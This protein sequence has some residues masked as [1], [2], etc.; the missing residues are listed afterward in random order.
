MR[1]ARLIAFSLVLS[2][3][4]RAA[5]NL[6]FDHP[7]WVLLLDAR[8]RGLLADPVGGQQALGEDE[9]QRALALLRL[10]PDP[11]LLP[12]DAE[13]FWIRPV[14]TATLRAALLHEHDRP[15][16]TA[17]RPRNL[18]GDLGVSCELQEGRPC[19]GGV[20]LMPELD[21]SAG[22]GSWLSASTRLRLDAGNNGYAPAVALDRAYLKAQLGFLAIEAGRDV[23]ALG[24][25]ARAALLVSRNAA[26]LDML[27]AWT[28]PLELPFFD[29][30]VS[31]LYFI[32]RLRDPQ[33]Y[34]GTFVDCTRMQLD[35]FNHL[36][37]GGSR[38]L[39]FGGSGAPTIG[40]GSF[41]G[42]HFSR[43]Y[44]STG[45]PLGDNRLAFD[46]AV[47]VP[48]LAGARFYTEVSFEDFRKQELNVF[49]YDADYLLGV[50]FRA[51]AAG[52][53][54]RVLFEAAKTGRLSQEGLYWLTGWTNAGRT[55]GSPLGPDGL[56]LYLHG[57]LELPFGRVSPWAEALRFSSDTFKD[58]GLGDG[59]VTVDRVGPAEKRL[60][61]GV[62]LSI[63]LRKVFLLEAN[64]YV[65]RVTTADFVDGAVRR[66]A[67]ALASFRY[68]SAF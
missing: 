28:R 65:E 30:R 38:L 10:A 25:S 58:D 8:A 46:A 44:D 52:P 62:E 56:S 49:R 63:P 31:F 53:L 35:L 32:A 4:A 59:G 23:V 7:D 45:A 39:Q 9:V 11:R 5:P 24:Q 13:G 20:G 57:D 17:L 40:L 41:I 37:L 16:S 61:V 50:E 29:A 68:L 48:A 67:G 55:L 21:S 36:E 26:P 47:T 1:A 60:R 18:V 43:D 6:P 15:Y 2:A 22:F 14:E 34:P 3:A 64:L 42:E 12:P 66:N 19:G 54:R 51:L 27:R 33:F